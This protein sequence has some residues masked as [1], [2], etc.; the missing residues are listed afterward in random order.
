MRISAMIE[1][2]AIALVFLLVF[3]GSECEE[4]DPTCSSAC[5]HLAY[6]EAEWLADEGRELSEAEEAEY[7]SD[8][9]ADC[10]DAGE[11]LGFIECIAEA[12][13]D[14]LAEGDCR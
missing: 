4:E 13:C 10:E 6:C 8:C 7:R 14:D 1:Q 9:V 3:S 5:S 11:P 2:L 12:S